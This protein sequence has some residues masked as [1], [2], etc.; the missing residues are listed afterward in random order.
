LDTAS[1]EDGHHAARPADDHAEKRPRDEWIAVLVVR[2]VGTRDADRDAAAVTRR[3][4]DP[5]DAA[6]HLADERDR[7]DPGARDSRPGAPTRLRMV[8]NA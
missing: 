8:V 3:F 1:E 6:Q 5:D 2:L 4:D 7:E